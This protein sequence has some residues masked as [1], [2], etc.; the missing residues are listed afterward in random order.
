MTGT[1]NAEVHN[2]H[3]PALRGCALALDLNRTLNRQAELQNHLFQILAVGVVLILVVSQRQLE[4]DPFFIT[5]HERLN[6][7]GMQ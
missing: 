1:G 2:H 5:F 6:I 3:K 4:T 7:D